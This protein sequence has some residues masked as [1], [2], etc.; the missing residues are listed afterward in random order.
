MQ[1]MTAMKIFLTAINNIY[2]VNVNYGADK[3]FC[4]SPIF[5]VHL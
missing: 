3:T 1:K 5:L 4:F 2:L